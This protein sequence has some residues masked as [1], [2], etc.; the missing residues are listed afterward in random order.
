MPE[1]SALSADELWNP[2]S[3]LSGRVKTLRDEYINI[4]EREFHN[5]ITPFTTG[6]DWDTMW[7][8][9]LWGVVPDLLAFHKAFMETL[10]LVSTK[11]ELQ[12]DFWERSHQVRVATFFREVV[13]K[14]LPIDIL[15]GELI[16]GGR[17]NVALSRAHNRKEA[18]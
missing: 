2:S 11:V 18:K 4:Y 9:C 13:S 1:S 15:K 6:T 5:E 7:S 12:P 8:P 14:Y 17:F 3:E 16:V 10:P